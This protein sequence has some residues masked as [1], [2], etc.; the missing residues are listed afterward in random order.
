MYAH[1]F[2]QE[3]YSGWQNLQNLPKSLHMIFLNAYQKKNKIV[4]IILN[5]NLHIFHIR[6][7][8]YKKE[9][10]FSRH[11]RH[12]LII[13]NRTSNENDTYNKLLKIK[14]YIESGKISFEYAAKKYSQDLRSLKQGGDLGWKINH[15]FNL[16]ILQKIN[17]LK[18]NNITMPVRSDLGWHIIQLVDI[19]AYDNTYKKY[20]SKAYKIL[21]LKKISEN[22]HYWL[23]T[24]YLLNYIEKINPI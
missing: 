14:N 9:I 24:E 2:K 4:L 8:K 6:D 5:N 10:T 20:L 11:I 21:F 19:K 16:F 17:Y 3:S 18:K 7:I 13:P 1:N 15:K 23:K 22:I 12:I